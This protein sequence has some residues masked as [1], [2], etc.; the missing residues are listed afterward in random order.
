MFSIISGTSLFQTTGINETVLI[1][2]V[3]SFLVVEFY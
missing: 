2:A 3:V 1:G